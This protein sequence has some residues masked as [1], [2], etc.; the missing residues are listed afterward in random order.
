MLCRYFRRLI[1]NSPIYF[2]LSEVA[3]MN[4]L[5]NLWTDHV[6]WTRE[7]IISTAASLSAI[8]AVTARLLQNPSDFAELLS[9]VYGMEVAEN[10]KKL[11]T[12]HLLIAA[13]LVNAAKAGDTQKV[14]EARVKWY[15]NADEIAKFLSEI[16]PY[17]SEMLWQKYM[18][19]HLAMTEQEAVARLNGQYEEDVK[20]FDQIKE[21]ALEMADYMFEGIRQQFSIS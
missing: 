10:F 8:D 6:M 13:D 11:F 15:N 7:F 18:Y 19:G 17:W 5:R 1:L 14:D 20:L 4:Q 9:M 21:E 12:E 3:L 2:N 16:N